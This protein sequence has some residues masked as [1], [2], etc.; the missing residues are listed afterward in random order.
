[1]CMRVRKNMVI[2][3]KRGLIKKTFNGYANDKLMRNP[4]TRHLSEFFFVLVRDPPMKK[5]YDDARKRSTQI[6]TV[7]EKKKIFTIKRKLYNY[8]THKIQ[9]HALSL[10]RVRILAKK[11]SIAILYVN[12]F[13]K[14]EAPK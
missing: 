12:F 3:K 9:I 13:A 11:Y 10:E 1:M 2:V 4:F 14:F 8:I 6:T 5:V 7:K